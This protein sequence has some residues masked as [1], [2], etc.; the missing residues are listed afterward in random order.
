MAKTKRKLKSVVELRKMGEE[1]G[2]LGNP[3]FE[4]TLTRYE[5]QTNVLDELQKVIDSNPPIIERT[6]S[7]GKTTIDTH[8]AIRDYNRTTDSANKTLHMLLKFIPA[9]EEEITT[10]EEEEKEETDPLLELINGDGQD[11]K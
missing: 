4:T 11:G 1:A 6:L 2:L 9:S 10:E 8:P 7:N 3:L 5:T